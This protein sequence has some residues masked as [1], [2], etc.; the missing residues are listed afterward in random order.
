MCLQLRKRGVK[1]LLGDRVPFVIINGNDKITNLAEDPM[2]AITNGLQINVSYYLNNQLKSPIVGLLEP[3]IGKERANA[4]VTATPTTKRVSNKNPLQQFVTT[5]P[6]CTNCKARV[7]KGAVVCKDCEPMPPYIKAINELK[8]VEMQHSRM[9]AHCQ[10][11][12]KTINVVN[13]SNNDCP[14]FY[15]RITIKEQ[16]KKCTAAID[17]FNW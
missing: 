16:L 17:R 12:A 1:V 10:A 8:R 15:S 7:K 6:V 4:I 14:I 2:F 9:W 11:C 5:I 3:V 13:C